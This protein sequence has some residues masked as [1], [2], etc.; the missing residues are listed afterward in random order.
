[1]NITPISLAEL[2]VY[3]QSSA[4]LF[5]VLIR[6]EKQMSALPPLVFLARGLFTVLTRKPVLRTHLSASQT[7]CSLNAPENQM[8]LRSA[9]FSLELFTLYRD[10]LTS[11]IFI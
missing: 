2:P 9:W 8:L 7:V 5:L 1:M 6:S 10:W 3:A 4:R 11:A